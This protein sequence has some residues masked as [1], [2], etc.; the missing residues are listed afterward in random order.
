MKGY[1]LGLLPEDEASSLEEKGLADY[2]FFE[3][4]L[5]VENQLI[6]DYLTGQLSPQYRVQFEKQFL[7]SP[8]RR[9]R[10]EFART[11]LKAM[12]QP[13]SVAAPTLATSPDQDPITV[14]EARVTAAKISWQKRL[15][16]FFDFNSWGFRLAVTAVML[17]IAIAGWSFWEARRVREELV[18]IKREKTDLQ[19]RE[20]DLEAKLISQQ[21]QTEELRKELERNRAELERLKAEEAKL[22]ETLVQSSFTAVASI[23]WTPR[24]L[25][26]S[27]PGQTPHLTINPNTKLARLTVV[28]DKKLIGTIL[29]AYPRVRAELSSGGKV[30]WIEQDLQPSSVRGGQ[31]FVVTLPATSLSADNYR[32]RLIGSGPSGETDIVNHPFKVIKK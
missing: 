15:R 2:D 8:K 6:D 29:E 21:G 22:Q 28:L 11:F 18:Q 25:R 30:R 27:L 1:L 26:R 17:L 14:P 3:H 7:L 9:E 20:R 24:G 13:S 23:I 16:S 31:A 4:L 19:Q 32:I 5:I 12:S 10:V